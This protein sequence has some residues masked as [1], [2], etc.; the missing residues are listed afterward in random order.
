ML[1]FAITAPLSWCSSTFTGSVTALSRVGRVRRANASAL[2]AV[3]NRTPRRSVGQDPLPGAATAMHT[4]GIV[5]FDDVEELDFVGPYEMFGVSRMLMNEASADP[6]PV[7]H[8]VLIAESNAAPVRCSKGMRVMA[9]YTYDDH[10]PLDVVVVPG[11]AGTRVMI[12]NAAIVD[13]LRKV[14]P[15]SAWITSVCTGVSLLHKAGLVDGRRVSTHWRFEDELHEMGR[16]TV[17]RDADRYVVDGNVVTSQGVAAGIDMSLWLI[18]QLHT[19]DHARAVQK[20][21]QYYPNPPY[22]TI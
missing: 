10:P 21:A 20:R 5:L 9:D 13:W 2:T 19:P 15:H 16:V 7:Y 18:G 3:A 1:A 14:A 6:E 11:G 22:A 8:P 4:I 12:D 17:V